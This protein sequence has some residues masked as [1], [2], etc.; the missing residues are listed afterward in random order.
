MC[1]RPGCDSGQVHASGN[2]QHD[3]QC[4][5]LQDMLHLSDALA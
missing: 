3:L 1:L 2:S 5:S 4:L